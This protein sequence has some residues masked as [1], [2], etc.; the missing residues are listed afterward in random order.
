MSQ[1]SRVI[2]KFPDLRLLSISLFVYYND[3]KNYVDWRL[4]PS[5]NVVGSKNM[6]NAVADWSIKSD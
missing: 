6:N 5:G 3:V 2:L 4:H 1:N